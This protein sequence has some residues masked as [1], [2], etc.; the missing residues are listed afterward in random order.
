[1]PDWSEKD[2]DNFHENRAREAIESKKNW[3]LFVMKV[4]IYS[5]PP[6]VFER[7]S[8]FVSKQTRKLLSIYEV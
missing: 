8:A 3:E 6:T 7:L 1:M 4:L 2:Y 5:M